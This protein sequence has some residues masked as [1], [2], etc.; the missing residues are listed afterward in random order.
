VNRLESLLREVK[1]ALATTPTVPPDVA[2]FQ[3]GARAAL[4]LAKA[5]TDLP[6]E[7]IEAP[8]K[9]L[10]DKNQQIVNVIKMGERLPLE[11]LVGTPGVAK[12]QPT[13]RLDDVPPTL[14]EPR[15]VDR[16][17]GDFE[18]ELKR[19]LAQLSEDA[20][21]LCEFEEPADDLALKI[22]A[23]RDEITKFTAAARRLLTSAPQDPGPETDARLREGLRQ[24]RD[25]HERARDIEDEYEPPGDRPPPPPPPVHPRLPRAGEP[26]AARPVVMRRAESRPTSDQPLWSAIRNRTSA[27]AFTPYRAF[28]DQV[29]CFEGFP[30]EKQELRGN[31]D[32]E[33]RLPFLRADAYTRLKVAT[34]LFMMQECGV[35][36]DERQRW[37][38]R[39]PPSPNNPFENKPDYDLTPAGDRRRLYDR[40]EEAGRLGRDSA[41]DVSGPGLSRE[42]KDLYLIKL[43][44][45]Q[46]MLPYFAIIREKLK[47]L[48]LKGRDVVP[49][50]CYGIL[51]SQ[52]TG[53]C[54]LELIW[55]FWHEAGFLVR[56]MHVVNRRF[57]NI[58]AGDRD[59]LTRFDLDTLRPLGNLLWGHI[60]DEQ[61]RLTIQRRVYEYDHHYGLRLQNRPGAL[62]PADSR[63]KFIA[64]FHNLLY[65]T[66]VFYKEDDDTTVI[67]DAFRVLNG[68]RE[69]HLLLAEGAH[70]QFGDLPWTARAEM[71]MEQWLL[72]RPEMREFLGGR[73]AVPYAE[74]WMDRVDTMKT[75]QGWN[76]VS[77]THFHDLAVCGEQ[78][79]LSVRYGNWSV[80]N[81]GP[82]AANW[83]RYWRPEIQRY[84]HAYQAVT[85]V[86]L[87]IEPV[88]TTSPAELLRQRALAPR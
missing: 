5:I 53:P 88:D 1:E 12:A 52:L 30:E 58:R 28:I 24:G 7:E 32:F 35:Y 78:I 25:L 23:I 22:S 77:V 2:S 26:V 54:L 87:A 69:V 48:P 67:A 56:S 86:D 61:H 39:E 70:N 71:L 84:I 14:E 3:T 62:H 85:G 82:Q 10:G 55:S 63:S 64:A 80:V 66:S 65:L 42:L 33:L 50:N 19:L 74:P 27:I 16:K 13:P 51:K 44:Q 29:M 73:I 83:A 38:F 8:E 9:T 60:S 36:I 4:K 59:P 11:V 18:E 21:W 79:L 75:L 34:E 40:N 76:D 49:P 15:P 47:E 68:L 41:S 57:Q 37:D 81:F 17:Q 6:D 46:H 43:G 72:A 20:Q 31:R 45:E